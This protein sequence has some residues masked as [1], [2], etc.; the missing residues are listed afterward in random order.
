M[1]V[2]AAN[3][4]PEVMWVYDNLRGWLAD[5]GIEFVMARCTSPDETVA[6]GQ[7]AEVALAFRC[8]MTRQVLMGLPNLRLLMSS[9]IGYDHIDVEAATD[10]G[11]IVTNTATYCVQDV[12]EHAL[13]LILACTRKI[14]ALDRLCRQGDWAH[15]AV[16][17]LPMHRFG[18]QTVGIIGLGKIGSALAQRLKA[19]G[20]RVLAH[21]PYAPVEQFAVL[22]A[23]SVSLVD[24]LAQA[25]FVS[26]HPPATPETWHM[27]GEAQLRA[28]KPTAFLVNT[29]RGPVV[30]GAALLRALR[31]GWIAGAALDVVEGEPLS[32]DNP[33]LGL[34][35]V[36]LTGHSAGTSVEGIEDW[37]AEWRRILTDYLE[38]R[39]PINVVNPGVKPQANLSRTTREPG[40][41]TLD[42]DGGGLS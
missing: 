26:L 17:A 35:N 25:D 19:L 15:A 34:E 22:E 7:G 30:D 16:R 20:F 1:R 21:D 4:N 9:G 29:S 39:W 37:Q 2:F 24:L 5:R 18:S 33:L 28:M 42:K 27:I 11:I 3:Y 38:G 31:E 6:V 32:L 12:A 14:Q 8:L 10:L 36:L 41:R 40:M 23:M 13:A